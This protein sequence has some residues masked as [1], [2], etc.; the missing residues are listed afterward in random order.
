MSQLDVVKEQIGYLK[1]WI[2]V[3]IV[4]DISMFGWLATNF[5]RATELLLDGA[6]V[7]MI[8]LVVS[9]FDIHRRIGRHIRS[10]KSL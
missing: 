7:T 6:V 8:S 3:L 4:T 5:G 1:L 10:L 2:G 9:I